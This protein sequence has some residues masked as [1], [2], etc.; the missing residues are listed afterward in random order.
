MT[1]A[2]LRLYKNQKLDNRQS[3]DLNVG[4]SKF[5]IGIKSLPR[6]LLF[7]VTIDDYRATAFVK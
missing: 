1:I 7:P 5:S 6:G 2:L 4:V 3:K